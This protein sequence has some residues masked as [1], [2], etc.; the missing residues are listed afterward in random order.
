MPKL[1]P[2]DEDRPECCGKPMAIHC[3]A[4]SGNQRYRC[5]TCGTT[6]TGSGFVNVGYDEAA[7]FVY[8]AK[9]QKALKD[10]TLKTLVVTGAVNNT[11]K[12]TPF[13]NSLQVLC[14]DRKAKLAIFPINYK[15]VSAF[16][17]NQTYNKQW[18]QALQPY[19]ID[20]PL[21]FGGIM[22]RPDI[23]IAATSANPLSG[24]DAING[25]LWTVFGSTKFA[26]ET[27]SD[28]NKPKRT[29]T[30]GSIT[31]NN[32]S[33]TDVGAKAEFHHVNGALII[34]TNGKDMWVR[35]LNCD[36][37][38]RFYDLDRYYT[39]KKVTRGHRIEALIPGDEHIKFN[40]KSVRQATYDG[41]NS[42]VKLLRPKVIVRHDVLDSYAG[43]HH[44]EKDD[45]LQYRKYVNGDNDFR[46]E[47]DQAVDFINDTTPKGCKN[48]FVASNH[49][50]HLYK[51]L[52]RVDPKLDHTNAM[53]IHEL[54]QLQYSN[55]IKGELYEQ[56]Y[57]DPF[58]L[59]AESRLKGD[60]VF[61]QRSKECLVAGVDVG[62]H[63]DV[64]CNGT[65]GSAQGMAKSVRKRVIGHSHTARIFLGVYQMGTSTGRLEYAKG[66]SSW[67]NTHAIIYKG[68]K[69]ALIDI[70]HG[71]FH[72]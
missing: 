18:V 60:F 5:I 31:V 4:Q 42:I 53:L 33:Q 14:K 12:N 25:R 45:V 30:T 57:T 19:I 2:E 23:K 39:P 43:S 1:I 65:R 6:T 26:M 41:K 50:D 66:L 22:L 7:A 68:G 63:G 9:L 49:V 69:R 34:E 72:S 70:F 32:Y 54:K 29:Y 36:S 61:L 67:T 27:I 40:K 55:A 62:Q 20:Q 21:K 38:G 10:G 37:Q 47:L 56:Y 51:W 59:Y 11:R 17:S 28:M 52:S 3:K 71:G 46:K 58:K 24:K 13:F 48:I 8:H 15:N 44:H 35:H 16:T 64:G